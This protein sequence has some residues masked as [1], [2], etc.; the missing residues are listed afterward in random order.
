MQGDYDVLGFRVPL[1]V[2]SPWARPG[3][4]SHRASDLTSLLR[5]V[6]ARFGIPA[7]TARDANALALHDMFDFTQP[8]LLVPPPLPA[9]VIEANRG[10]D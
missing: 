1:V 6:E 2:V 5:F 4:V 7:L 8:A 3:H 10:C 9:A